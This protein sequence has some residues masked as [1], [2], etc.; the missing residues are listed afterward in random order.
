M[1]RFAL[2]GFQTPNTPN[3]DGRHVMMTR[4]KLELI[5]LS[6]RPKDEPL[7]H[8]TVWLSIDWGSDVNLLA[9]STTNHFVLVRDNPVEGKDYMLRLLDADLRITPGTYALRIMEGDQEIFKKSVIVQNRPIPAD[10]TL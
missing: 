6:G 2:P 4:G 8:F 3:A 1:E 5:F 7:R 9:Y 10:P